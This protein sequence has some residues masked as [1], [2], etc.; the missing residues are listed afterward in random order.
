M[1][2]RA[3]RAITLASSLASDFERAAAEDRADH[4]P[5]TKY[6]RDPVAYVRQR[7]HV[8]VVMPHQEA[9]LGAIAK[10]VAGESVP[11]IATRS[12]QKSGKTA[13]AIWICLWFYECFAEARVFLCAAIIEQ[14]KLVLW[15]ELRQTLR[16]AR[17]AGSQIDGHFAQS[18]MGGLVSSDGSRAIKGVSGREIES[19]AG[20]SGRQLTVIDE[21]SHLPEKKAQ[22]FEG[23][24][25]GGDG[26]QFWISNP[27][28]NAGPFYDAFHK[29]KAFWQT[30]HIDGERVAKWQEETG[31][32]IPYTITIDRVEEA[33]ERY[34][35]QSPFWLL[36]VKGEWLRN[37]TGRAISMATIEEALARWHVAPAEGPLVIGY[38]CAGP[39]DGGDEHC[40]AVTRGAKCEAIERERG[41]DEDKAVKFTLDL[42]KARRRPHE[43]P[44]VIIDSEG[45]IGSA[46]YGRL[47]GE[48]E[49]RRIYDP[50]NL[51]EVFGVKGS[52]KHVRDRDKFERVRDELVWNLAEWIA[53][54]AIPAD[55]KLQAE[56]Y[57]PTW[58]SLPDSRLKITPKSEIRDELGRSPDSFDALALSVW[59]PHRW[60]SEDDAAAAPPAP[61]PPRDM[62]DANNAWFDGPQP[63]APSGDMNE[64]WW[65]KS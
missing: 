31:V 32:R 27:T 62:Q 55:D 58:K 48:A 21:A 53:S 36:R 57:A 54:G 25:L 18:P 3:T 56:L 9:I 8:A 16:R 38:D 11:R 24:T 44:R 49:H 35:E 23:N 59:K 33:R 40:W 50:A 61:P 51:F 65:P 26:F 13:M 30:F 43:I 17:E 46:L 1:K 45:P 41:L 7:L 15:H 64:P 14:T 4:Y 6:Q 12:G 22:V 39:G 37:E 28:R 34:G 42:V 2:K 5:L 19:I 60:R 10:S 29:D 63:G 52:S 47:R 20:L